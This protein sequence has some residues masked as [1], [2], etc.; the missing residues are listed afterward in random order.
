MSVLDRNVDEKGQV[1]THF[2]RQ[3]RRIDSVIESEDGLR[4]V[5]V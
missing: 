4:L 5:S 3:M 2:S 1:S